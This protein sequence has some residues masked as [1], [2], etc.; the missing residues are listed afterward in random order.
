MHEGHRGFVRLLVVV[1]IA[2]AAWTGP[3]FPQGEC[4][5]SGRPSSEP[6]GVT[7]PGTTAATASPDGTWT[8]VLGLARSSHTAVY[9]PA[10]D[11]MVIFGGAAQCGG[12]GFGDVWAL[13]MGGDPVWTR[14]EPS[15][16]PPGPRTGYGAVFDPAR[17]RVLIFGGD[18]G[19]HYL[20]DVWALTLG[21]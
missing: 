5:R 8:S 10:E 6:A 3:A 7:S 21:P 13:T 18:D 2:A 1:S 17:G 12:Y 9:D 4:G 11:G 15:G 20:N 14:L 19:G 16:A